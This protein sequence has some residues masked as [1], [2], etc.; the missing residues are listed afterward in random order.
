MVW[1]VLSTCDKWEHV[2]RSLPNEDTK[3]QNIVQSSIVA[4]K[5]FCMR[6]FHRSS[7]KHIIGSR[8]WSN[9]VL[10]MNWRLQKRSKCCKK[11]TVINVYFVRMFSNGMV[12]FAMAERAWMMFREWGAPNHSNTKTHCKSM[13]CFGRW[14]TLNNQDIGRMVPHW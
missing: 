12:S 5:C 9:F 1:V 6:S 11:R 13:R 3:F 10:K 2:D 8:R 4:N 7:W 14:S